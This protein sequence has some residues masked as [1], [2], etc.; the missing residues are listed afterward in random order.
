MKTTILTTA[1]LLATVFGLSKPAFASTE[2]IEKGTTIL[3]NVSNINKIEVHGNV[4]LY[5]S[6]GSVDQVKVYDRYYAENALVQD[7]KGVLRISSYKADKLV[8]WVT[9]NEL[10]SLS[11]YDNSEVKSFGKLSFI[12]LDVKLFDNAAAR[13]DMDVFSANVTLRGHA[14][15]DIEGNI[16]EGTLKYDRSS[17]LNITNLNSTKVMKMVNDNSIA[18]LPRLTSL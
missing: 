8:V 12:D 2:N 7:D 1:I 6:E 18:G 11:V 5:V 10:S 17:Y 15:A 3:P 14:K 4:E 13:L 9:V 16:E